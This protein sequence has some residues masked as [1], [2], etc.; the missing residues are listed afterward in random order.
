[1]TREF[2]FVGPVLLL[3]LASVGAGVLGLRPAPVLTAALPRWLVLALEYFVGQGVLA[4]L[5]LALG[6][7][8]CFSP[9]WLLPPLGL[10][11]IVGAGSIAVRW[12]HS[13]AD[14]TRAWR[15]WR[16]ASVT[17]QVVSAATAG[18]FLYGFTSV[19]G[20]LVVDS[21]AFYMAMSRFI[22]GT[23]QLTALPGY[24]GFSAVGLFGE[25][26]MAAL[27]TL[28]MD[29][30][31]P[32]VLSWVAF[33]PTIAVVY[34]L[35]RLC[36]LGRR[37]AVITVAA[38]V[39]STSIASLWG[40]GKTDLFP[41]GPALAACLVIVALW[42]RDRLG[43]APFIAGLL[44][45]SAALAK[46]SYIVAF[47]PALAILMVWQRAHVRRLGLVGLVTAAVP[48]GLAFSAGFLFM[49][50]QNLVKNSVILGT[51]FASFEI[52]PMFS[53]ATVRRLLLTYP[54]ALTYGRYW[55]QLGT[56][57]PIVLAFLPLVPAYLRWP[58]RWPES[59]L[60]A[61]SLA[62]TA[63]L[64][65]WVVLFPSIVM[66]RYF[67]ATLLLFA[68][69]AA[70]AAEVAT[71]RSALLAWIV[72]AGILVTLAVTPRQT[73]I[74]T[75]SSLHATLAMVAG[76]HQLC[77]GSSPFEADCQAEV[78]I[79]Q[80]AQPGD[81]VLGLSYLRF[82]L[83]PGLVRIMST[84]TEVGQLRHCPDGP[85][86][87]DAFWARVRKTGYRFILSDTASHPLPAGVL[88]TPPPDIE[89][90]RLFTAGTISSWE[91]RRRS[92]PTE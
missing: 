79:N 58:A 63:G 49:F 1:M 81:R 19:A 36:G 45:G 90:R 88:E 38:A 31:T 91:I 66:L 59:R 47:L 61:V 8:G 75:F 18:L 53:A 35:A 57:S 73:I 23:G 29:G 92:A 11:A 44:F 77:K 28:G 62:A 13:V 69:P 32:R 84:S 65:T 78:E 76:P 74:P 64:L 56:L 40:A 22:A 85:C 48:I 7:A 27:F 51:P 82:W 33:I 26:H 9:A 24:E 5:F 25:L 68:L 16:A 67:E 80:A 15:A 6:L 54:F 42:H 60:L 43:P 20:W 55:A 39:S 72:P 52:D 46:V 50:G 70:A 83:D 86:S 3:S 21:P 12:P 30:T 71:R 14:A 87:A 17:W 10:L 34:G 37:G 89:L 4:T 2:W 41:L